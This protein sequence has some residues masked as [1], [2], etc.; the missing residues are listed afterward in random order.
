MNTLVPTLILTV[1][2]TGVVQ[3]TLHAYILNKLGAAQDTERLCTFAGMATG[4]VATLV[5]L[6][7]LL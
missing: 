2:L 5:S 1:G 3:V 6:W 4:A 7:M